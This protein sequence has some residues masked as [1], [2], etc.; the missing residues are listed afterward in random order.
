MNLF[1]V[2]F[3]TTRVHR[4][5]VL[6]VPLLL[7]STT[8]VVASPRDTVLQKSRE[9]STGAALVDTVGGC[10]LVAVASVPIPKD[11]RPDQAFGMASTA[12]MLEARAEAA[13]FLDGVYRTSSAAVSSKEEHWVETHVES[14]ARVRLTSGEILE[15]A[16]LPEGR[17][18]VAMSWGLTATKTEY[19][20]ID[21]KE[22]TRIANDALKTADLPSRTLSW[23]KE[24]G[25]KEGLLVV[26]AVYPDGGLP[27]PCNPNDSNG[28]SPC[29]SC[30][31]CRKMT[32]ESIFEQTVGE[33]SKAGDVGVAQCM[34]RFS[35][36]STHKIREGE[37]ARARISKKLVH[38]QSNAETLVY[39]SPKV[40][41]DK[42][43]V[44]RHARDRSVYVAFVPMT[45]AA[46]IPLER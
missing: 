27:K 11:R 21:T 16:R 38:T 12:A 5:L 37:E 13:L 17:V 20:P 14:L 4:L 35:G 3:E 33:W 8:P 34:T 28:G 42:R 10:V 29:K 46:G 9:L 24:S 22:L 32:L 15:T 39:I 2:R 40:L 30:E 44:M 43:V 26:V 25:G 45:P 1:G 31:L 36:H 41:R 23:R 18:R 6:V 19:A 7:G